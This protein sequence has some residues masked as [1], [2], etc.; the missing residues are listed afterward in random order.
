MNKET[1]KKINDFNSMLRF[2]DEIN[3]LPYILKIKGNRGHGK[4]SLML[5]HFREMKK[6]YKIDKS[7]EEFIDELTKNGFCSVK[8]LVKR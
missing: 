3:K 6:Y 8:I 7:D 1:V 5:K 4:N 2:R